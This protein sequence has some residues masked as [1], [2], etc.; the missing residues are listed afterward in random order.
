MASRLEQRRARLRAEYDFP[1]PDDLFRFWEFVTRLAPLDPLNA[2]AD[3]ID[4]VL[5]GPFEVLAGRFDGRV[6]RHSLL[7]HWRYHDDPPEFFTVLASGEEGFH[8]GYYLDDPEQLPGCVACYD[9]GDAFELTVSGDTLF[10][11]VRLH[12]EYCHGDCEAYQAADDE[13]RHA[14]QARLDALDRLRQRLTA[15]ATGDR[16]EVGDRY[17]E[18]HA[19][20]NSRKKRVI[21]RTREGMGI[22]ADP[23]LYRP[24]A[25]S[26][27]QLW[28]QLRRAAD[29]LELVEE[30]RQ[31]LADG[32][33]ATAL[34][35]GKE[36]WATGRRRKM[37][38]A[39]ELLDAAYAAL[40]RATLRRVLQTHL[41]HRDLP[42][43]D[44]LDADED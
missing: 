5:V 24:L 20:Q 31:A 13:H 7:L 11:A 21:A 16:P 38:H 39:A 33:P 34:K 9:A 4:L 32:F 28:K 41:A 17:S 44:I 19:T 35:L 40:G 25:L 23:A 6:P 18:R 2:L 12:L 42:S 36:L 1:F 10:D 26:D 14:F 29:P 8:H 43:V 3:A 22:V 27:R 30:A 15:C 37:G